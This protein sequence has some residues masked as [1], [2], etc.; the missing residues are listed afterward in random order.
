MRAMRRSGP[1]AIAHGL[2][3]EHTFWERVTVEGT[4]PG[5]SQPGLGSVNRAPTPCGHER[6]QRR[7]EMEPLFFPSLLLLRRAQADREL[8]PTEENAGNPTESVVVLVLVPALGPPN[9]MA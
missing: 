5:R 9:Q 1:G 7:E 4:V 8:R 6:L 3:R 2:V